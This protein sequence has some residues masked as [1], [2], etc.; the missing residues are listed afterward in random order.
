MFRHAGDRRVVGN[1]PSVN[2]CGRLALFTNHHGTEC[3]SR[4]DSSVRGPTLPVQVS[5]VDPVDA[6]PGQAASGRVVDGSPAASKALSYSEAGVTLAHDYDYQLVAPTTHNCQ[7]A[8]LMARSAMFALLP[9]CGIALRC[10]CPTRSRTGHSESSQLLKT[11]RS[12]CFLIRQAGGRI[13]LRPYFDYFEHP[14][15]R[16][17]I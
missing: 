12:I 16:R 9:S 10:P 6:F 3:G 15:T 11:C 17:T 4:G 5:R 14:K 1:D 8:R 7:T 13:A 2:R